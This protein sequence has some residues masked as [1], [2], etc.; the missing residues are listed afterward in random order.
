LKKV[1]SKG[2]ARDPVKR[3]A[4]LESFVGFTD[5]DW[6]ALA[7]SVEVLAPKLPG[8]LDAIYAHLLGHDDTRRIFLGMRGELD[9]KY[10]EVRKE[11]LTEWV[12]RTASGREDHDGFAHYLET[13]GRRH[14]GVE[15]EPHRQVPPR[16]MVG[17]TSFVQSGII[18][19]LFEC[20]PNDP[21]KVRRMGLAWNKMMMI[22]LEMFLKAMA[23][24]WPHWDEG[25]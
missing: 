7:E 19:T 6:K 20:L 9:P 25:V 16:Y 12:L 1:D 17:L 11:H 8:L 14:T 15:G 4:F 13:V 21:A 2:I 23:P 22:Q 5:E 3:L 10:I 24:Q 18:A